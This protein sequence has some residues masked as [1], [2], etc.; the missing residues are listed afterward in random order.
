MGQK[1]DKP[2]SRRDFIKTA[3]T[4]ALAVGVGANIVALVLVIS[5]SPRIMFSLSLTNRMILLSCFHS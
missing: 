1:K 4:A 2:V 3:G 5:S